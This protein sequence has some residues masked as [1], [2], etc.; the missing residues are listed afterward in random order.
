MRTLF[1]APVIAAAMACST[2]ALAQD[3]AKLAQEKACLSCHAVDKKLV[4]PAYKEIAA[5]YK[6]DKGA[7]A[8]LV[9]KVREG[10]VGA[11]GP[12]PM[13]PNTTVTEKEAQ[14]LVKWVLSQK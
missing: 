4:G 12:V 5:K 3:A 1:L 2:G 6:A 8:R 14:I 7:E 11:W 13:P 9:K 10:G